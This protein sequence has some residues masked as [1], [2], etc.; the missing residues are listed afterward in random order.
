[1]MN[2]TP[3]NSRLGPIH[4]TGKRRTATVIAPAA[5]K[6]V[7]NHG[8]V[9][10]MSS[11][12]V[13]GQIRV[14]A[15]RVTARTAQLALNAQQETAVHGC[16]AAAAST[17]NAATTTTTPTRL[18]VERVSAPAELKDNHHDVEI[19]GHHSAL[20]LQNSN[21][22]LATHLNDPDGAAPAAPDPPPRPDI[23]W[24]AM[25]IAE[26]K[27]KARARA[28]ANTRVDPTLIRAP[29]AKRPTD[30][31]AGHRATTTATANANMANIANSGIPR[32]AKT[33]AE[34]GFADTKANAR[35]GIQVFTKTPRLMPSVRTGPSR[36]QDPTRHTDD[37]G[38]HH[39][40]D[41]VRARAISLELALR[42]QRE[43]G[44]RTNH[45]ARRT[46][47]MHSCTWVRRA[48]WHV[49]MCRTQ[50]PQLCLVPL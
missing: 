20:D 24:I 34:L 14:D 8:D 39:R 1:M 28:R 16:E 32:I 30:K 31:K 36:P 46:T 15:H 42:P 49:Q 40:R 41:D 25:A 21:L 3:T 27:A 23:L 13:V 35:T 45:A 48:H 5:D 4:S 29:R 47:T 37:T 43:G 18:V 22:F 9:D 2:T 17:E 50:T 11:N 7:R 44:K 10:A 38:V 19:R 12:R 6:T 33:F 26:T